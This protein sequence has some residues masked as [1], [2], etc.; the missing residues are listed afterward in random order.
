ML[1]PLPKEISQTDSQ[2]SVY[3]GSKYF[4]SPYDTTKQSTRFT[5]ASKNIKSFTKTTPYSVDDNK[6]KYGPVGNVPPFSSKLVRI[7]FMNNEPILRAT[8]VFRD[9][10][11]SHWGNVRVSETYSLLN[12]GARLKGSFEAQSKYKHMNG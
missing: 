2:F 10:E 3:E 1:T 7:H 6:I 4:F 12:A 8:T 5:L 11:V 9:Y